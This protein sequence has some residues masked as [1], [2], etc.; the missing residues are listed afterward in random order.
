MAWHWLDY[1][2]VVLVGLS[3]ITGLLR[4]FVK[5]IIALGVWI[6]A[7]WA[8]SNYSQM[9]DPWVQPYIQDKM[10]RGIT[11]FM[12]IL[13]ATLVIGSVFNVILSLILRRSGLSGPDRL[14]GTG[15]GFMRGIFMVALVMVVVQMTSL[16]YQQYKN[17]SKLYAQ[18]D[19]LVHWLSGYMPN[20]LEKVKVFEQAENDMVDVMV[21]V[22]IDQS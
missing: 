3:V 1:S 8:A 17:Q 5:E 18:F 13:L 4:G 21:D 22:E 7:I 15:F 6:V 19:P 2:I 14:L 11:S 16:P 20:I 9:V 10:A 12:A